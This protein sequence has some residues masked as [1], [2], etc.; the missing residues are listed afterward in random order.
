MCW[1]N[2]TDVSGH[3]QTHS[4]SNSHQSTISHI[5]E[6]WDLQGKESKISTWLPNWISVHSPT[7]YQD[8]LRVRVTIALNSLHILVSLTARCYS[9]GQNIA[10]VKFINFMLN[11]KILVIKLAPW[12]LLRWFIVMIYLC[13]GYLRGTSWW[14]PWRSVLM[15]PGQCLLAWSECPCHIA[16]EQHIAHINYFLLDNKWILVSQCQGHSF[17]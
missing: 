11:H 15:Y 5:N 2:F 1:S 8:G 17:L 9:G 13:D 12:W 14:R 4:Y 10:A 7:H 16:T 3:N 6:L